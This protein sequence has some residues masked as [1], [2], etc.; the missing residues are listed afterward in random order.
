VIGQIGS[1]SLLVRTSIS[2]GGKVRMASLIEVRYYFCLW[3]VDVV[4][5]GRTKA[6]VSSNPY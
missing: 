2:V 4:D 5:R 1:V 6:V 3:E